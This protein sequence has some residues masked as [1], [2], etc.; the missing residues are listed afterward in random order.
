M[1]K[2]HESNP[3]EIDFLKADDVVSATECTGITPTPPED[4]SQSDSYANVYP[5]PKQKPQQ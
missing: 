5:I 4:S 1:M 2:M 3:N